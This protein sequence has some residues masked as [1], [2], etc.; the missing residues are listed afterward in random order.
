MADNTRLQT[1]LLPFAYWTQ[2]TDPRTREP[3]PGLGSTRISVSNAP[4]C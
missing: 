1:E 2:A 3:V 4:R